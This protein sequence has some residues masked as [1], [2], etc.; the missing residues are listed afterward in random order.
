MA[1]VLTEDDKVNENI[2]T[3]SSTSTR[4][5]DPGKPSHAENP[6]H[7]LRAGDPAGSHA[8]HVERYV[9]VATLADQR[10]TNLA[11]ATLE[12]NGVPVMV[13][14][15]RVRAQS[16]VGTAFRIL[17]PLSCVQNALGALTRLG[18]THTDNEAD[19][20]ESLSVNA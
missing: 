11:C 10:Q 4:R 20:D 5:A 12:S 6:I 15:V 9:L 19:N 7:Q 2:S 13:E 18:L 14:H 8:P 3:L 17:T 16:V 1:R